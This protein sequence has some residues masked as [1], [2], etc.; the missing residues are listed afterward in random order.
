MD[1]GG[2]RTRHREPHTRR[3]AQA[4]GGGRVRRGGRAR[5]FFTRG[6]AQETLELYTRRAACLDGMIQSYLSLPLLSESSGP[7]G[8]AASDPMG[9]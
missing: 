8:A 9:A 6:G 5:A 4:D 2:V 1:R 7:S 3:A